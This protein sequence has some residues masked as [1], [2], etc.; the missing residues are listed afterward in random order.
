M[1]LRPLHLIFFLLS[2]AAASVVACA[3]DPPKTPSGNGGSGGAPACEANA[4]CEAGLA[5]V[6]GVC[7]ACGSPLDCEKAQYCDAAELRCVFQPGWSDRCKLNEDCPLGSFC[8]QGNCLPSSQVE[9]CTNGK[10]GEG[11]RCNQ[12]NTVCEEDLGCFGDSDCGAE[13]RC[14]KGTGLCEAGC[15]DENQVD[16]CAA[17]ELCV[18]GRCV[19]C[20]EDE[21]CG[22]G[23]RCHV[24]AGR[25][26]GETSCLSDRDCLGQTVC[27]RITKTC[28]EQPPACISNSNCLKDER[29][30]L[31]SG[32][33]VLK[34]CVPDND[35]NLD[36]ESA[37]PLNP[38]EHHNKVACQGEEKWY[39]LA[40]KQ[41]DRVRVQVE[42]DALT[43]DGLEA[44]LRSESGQVLVSNPFTLDQTVSQDGAYFVR[45]R[46]KDEWLRYDLTVQVSAGEPCLDDAYPGN[47][48]PETA[49]R[50]NKGTHHNLVICPGVSDW[51][52]L[53]NPTTGSDFV[54]Q[55]I[56]LK[57][58]ELYLYASDHKALIDSDDS[59]GMQKSVKL[60]RF[61]H[62]IYLMVKATDKRVRT[63]Y[64]LQ[65]P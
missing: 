29:C 61:D 49:A 53:D 40:L 41:G 39:R 14:N 65:I 42:T 12:A 6:E 17:K 31:R 51:F 11:M 48:S 58:L 10:C 26:I 35:E 28:T 33:C 45:V 19:S 57:N 60:D 44:Q 16:V 2:M 5:C 55:Q 50:L 54:L 20:T 21:Q 1:S 13:Q 43:A 62:R 52:M 24:E 4:D 38:G 9:R 25:C 23:L 47:Q 46:T 27:N 59:E 3:D 34:T 8:S 22:P 56:D 18:E 30:D 15:T 63:T 32:R 37:L 36:Q 64:S 7:G